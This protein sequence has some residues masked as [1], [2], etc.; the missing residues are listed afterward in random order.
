MPTAK[1]RAPRRAPASPDREEDDRD[2]KQSAPRAKRGF[3]KPMQPDSDLA[4]IVGE[5]PLPRTEVIKRVWDYI[6]S[7]GL[8]D[9][10]NRRMINADEK[11][12]PL[13]GGKNRV[14]MF[15]MTKLV[16]EHLK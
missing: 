13:F 7:Q 16:N 11:L 15:E 3:M 1:K 6:K 14:S 5:E 9:R 8:Q 4:A 10:E 12:Q 2:Q